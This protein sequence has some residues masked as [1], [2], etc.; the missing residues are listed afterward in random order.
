MRFED[1]MKVLRDEFPHGDPLLYEKVHDILDMYDEKCTHYGNVDDP[2]ETFNDRHQNFHRALPVQYGHLTPL[3]YALTLAAK[4]DQAIWNNPTPD[5][6]KE[7]LTDGIVY[8]L[9]ALC[10]LD[11]T[12]PIK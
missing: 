5:R 4:H 1:F 10:L 6:M 8:R 7:Y 9:I 3:Q 12:E 2:P 11:E